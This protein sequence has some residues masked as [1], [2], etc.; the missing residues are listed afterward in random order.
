MT[1]G[2]HFP[3]LSI[4]R[5]FSIAL[6]ARLELS[7]DLTV[8]G[9]GVEQR[10]GPKLWENHAGPIPSPMRWSFWAAVAEQHDIPMPHMDTIQLAYHETLLSVAARL[11]LYD[12]SLERLY[13]VHYGAK[14]IYADLEDVLDL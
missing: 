11:R 6:D 9:T 7:R 4:G 14:L 3:A 13:R 1:N 2:T 5:L 10:V 8:W 12:A